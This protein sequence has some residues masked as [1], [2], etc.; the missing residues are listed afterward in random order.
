[1]S[2]VVLDHRG[3]A[4]QTRRPAALLSICAL[5][6][7]LTVSAGC[8]RFRSGT[9]GARD[10][11]ALVPRETA[12]I[13]MLNV[14]QARGSKLWQRL[15]ELREK[16]P[17]A[18]KE[19]QEFSA[20]CGLDPLQQ[21]DSVFLALPEN[22]QDSREYALLMRGRYAPDQISACA[23][24][25]AQDSGKSLTE[26]EYGGI[27]YLAEKEQGPALAVLGKRAV[28]I[29]GPSWL[30]RV[31]DLHTGKVAVDSSARDNPQ[32]VPLFGRTRTGDAFFW[33]GRT[34]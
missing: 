3:D 10:D 29:A 5:A 17:T 31:I 27:K 28:V 12:G 8:S 7:L 32:L 24:R 14:K 23:K 22:A 30:K 21:I 16:D 20:K 4:P 18:K 15:N 6:V 2:T 19:Y 34:S 33:A 25:V 26:A 9:L 1:M 13:F 11:L